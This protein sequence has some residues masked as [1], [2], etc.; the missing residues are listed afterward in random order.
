M[1]EAKERVRLRRIVF[2]T[3]ILVT[4]YVLGCLAVENDVN[5]A[6]WRHISPE[7][8]ARFHR[9]VEQGLQPIMFMPMTLHLLVG[10]FLVAL[11]PAPLRRIHV[12]P[13]VLLN[14]YVVVE[15]VTVQVPIHKALELAKTPE[16]VEALIAT[17]HMYR[18]PAEIA[19]GA[20]AAWLLFKVMLHAPADG[21]SRAA[22][23]VTFIRRMPNER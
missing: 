11:P 17:H 1:A 16:L 4:F 9:S 8:F 10:A 12:V 23:N 20:W 22:E 19:S 18:L 3:Y 15:S 7:D 2:A 6:T 14:L 5:Y 21:A 13:A